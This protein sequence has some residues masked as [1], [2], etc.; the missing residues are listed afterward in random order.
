MDTCDGRQQGVPE[1]TTAGPGKSRQ[2]QVGATEETAVS[3]FFL[4]VE[5]FQTNFSWNET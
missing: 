4:A 2:L 3:E 5:K 1:S